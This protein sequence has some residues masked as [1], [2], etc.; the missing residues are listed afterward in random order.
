MLFRSSQLNPNFTRGLDGMVHALVGAG[1]SPAA[2]PT[3]A[4]ALIYQAVGRQAQ[5]LSYID[6]FHTLMF[7]VFAAI[8]LLLIMRGPPAAGQPRSADAR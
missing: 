3:Q 1:Q 2:A 6:V 8:P 4:M 5:M 7:V